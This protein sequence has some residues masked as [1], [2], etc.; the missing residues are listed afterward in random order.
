MTAVFIGGSR[1]LPIAVRRRV[2]NIVAKELTV[3]IGDAN[4]ADKAIQTYLHEKHYA[5]SA[6]KGTRAFFTAKDRA[7][8]YAESSLPEDQRFDVG[9]LRKALGL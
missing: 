8:E 7:M 5:G 3:L 2:D 6:R 4:G 1:R 9:I